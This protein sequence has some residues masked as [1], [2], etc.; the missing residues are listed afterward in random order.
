VIRALV[1][2]VDANKVSPQI[3]LAAEGPCTGV[4]GADMR[5]QPVGV[6][7]RHV[8]FEVIGTSKGASTSLALVF[9]A[10]IE[11]GAV[12]GGVRVG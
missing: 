12:V 5:F 11:F 9:L 1:I 8:S 10:R 6:V 7:G 3:V 4:M 2:P